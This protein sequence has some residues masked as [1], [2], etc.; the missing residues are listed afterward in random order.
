MGAAISI[1]LFASAD[2][3]VVP[4]FAARRAEPLA[5]WVNAF[6]CPRGPRPRASTAEKRMTS[7]PLS[8]RRHPFSSVLS[9]RRGRTA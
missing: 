5:K 1:D 9:L 3:A 4:R 2:N 6:T 7:S 8:S